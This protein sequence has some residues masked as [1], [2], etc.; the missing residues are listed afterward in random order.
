M[1]LNNRTFY[2]TNQNVTWIS[3]LYTR[4]G[5]SLYDDRNVK[6][7]TFDGTRLVGRRDFSGW[8]WTADYRLEGDTLFT[9][10]QQIFQGQREM[11]PGSVAELVRVR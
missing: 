11:D 1:R 4:R 6:I 10:E 2:C 3:M 8:N 9:R 7:G 5:Q